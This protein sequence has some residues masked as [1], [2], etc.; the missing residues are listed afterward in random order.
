MQVRL[1]PVIARRSQL[2]LAPKQ[3]VKLVRFD[4]A[5]RRLVAGEGAAGVAA[6]TG[7]ADQSHLH[8]DVMAFTGATPAT[9]AAEPFLAVDDLAWP[10]RGTAPFFTS[11][12]SPDSAADVTQFP[13]SGADFPART[14]SLSHLRPRQKAKETA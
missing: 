13:T 1:S 12:G 11:S 14:R 5:A 8:R 2:G 6:G 7:Y 3:A 9:M 10:A 4:H